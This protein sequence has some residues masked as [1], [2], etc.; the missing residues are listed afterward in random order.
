[1]EFNYLAQ[2]QLVL[3]QTLYILVF[4]LSTFIFSI[5][6]YL[7]TTKHQKR[8][9]DSVLYTSIVISSICFIAA[10]IT[11]NYNAYDDSFNEAVF[12]RIQIGTGTILTACLLLAVLTYMH[13][14]K[15]T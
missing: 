5:S 11:S 9:R 4:I 2:Q 14:K 7:R 15:R 3:F 1:M 8:I 12:S 6:V 10:V 13:V